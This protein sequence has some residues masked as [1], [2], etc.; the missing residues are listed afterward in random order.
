MHAHFKWTGGIRRSIVTASVVLS[1]AIAAHAL[2][3]EAANTTSV[4]VRLVYFSN[5]EPAANQKIILYEGNP[6]KKATVSLAGTTVSD[7]TVT[8]T[9]SNRQPDTLWVDTSNGRIRACAWEPQLAV[10]TVEEEGVTILVDSRFG[11]TCKGDRG[12]AN[13]HTAKPGEIVIFVRKL[14]A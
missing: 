12:I 4:R 5:G 9:F 6:S 13:Q 7:G 14:T 10:K 1:F 3:T 2:L 11:H 8:F